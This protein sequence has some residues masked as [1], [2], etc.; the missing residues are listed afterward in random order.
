MRAVIFDID[1]TLLQSAAVDDDIYRSSVL[2]VLEGAVLRDSLHDYVHISDSG[3][4]AEIFADSGMAYDA[5]TAQAVTDHFVASLDAWMQDNGSFAEIP[6][7]GA[8]LRHLTKSDSF[9][10]GIA[11]G[12]WRESAELKLRSAGLFDADIPLATSS[13]AI[14]RTAI[15]QHALKQ[16][17]DRFDSVTYYGDGAWDEAASRA[18]GWNFVAVG[19]DLDGLMSFENH[20]FD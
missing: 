2:Q 16:M 3:I 19:R 12:G 1:G 18:L 4:L 6:G 11:T 20:D 15:M 9:A 14:E 5:E 7:A 17:G 10:V 13:D 8:A